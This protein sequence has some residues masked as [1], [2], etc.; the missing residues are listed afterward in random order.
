MSE[1][2]GQAGACASKVKGIR[3]SSLPLLFQCIRALDYKEFAMSN[4]YAET[5]SLIHLGIEAYHKLLSVDA[6]LAV[7]ATKQTDYPEA[8]GT[9]AAHA[10]RRYT[11]EQ[12][13]WGCIKGTEQAIAFELAPAPFDP[14]Q[15]KI[16]IEGTLDQIRD[17]GTT[18]IADTKTGSKPIKWM[19]R[20]YAPQ[21]AAYQY[22]YYHTT[23][24]K[25]HAAIIRTADFLQGGDIFHPVPWR[26]ET[27][28]DM[29]DTV[30]TLIALYRMGLKIAT[31]GEHCEWCPAVGIEHCGT[32]KPPE[33]KNRIALPQVKSIEDLFK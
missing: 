32:G 16:I 13:R 30:R 3:A 12:H 10:F 15:E 31:P 24:I 8:S 20:H 19:F 1:L 9:K 2:I 27:V 11:E 23:G 29:M 4:K 25:P 22:G 28:I 18:I 33:D 21:L 26:W 6:A 5:G 17:N 14:T 7:M